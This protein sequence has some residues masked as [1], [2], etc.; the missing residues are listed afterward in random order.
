MLRLKSKITFNVASQTEPIIFDFVNDVEINISHTDLTATAKIIVPRKLTFNGKNIASGINAIFRRGDKVK[1]ELGYFPNLRT[2]FEGYISNININSPI[3]IECEDNMFLL[4]K[5]NLLYPVKYKTVTKGKKGRKL[6]HPKIIPTTIKLKDFLLQ[7]IT[8]TTNDETGVTT[9]ELELKCIIDMSINIIRFDCSAAKA[10][11]KLKSTFVGLYAYFQDG[12]LNVGLDEEAS[13]SKEVEFAFEENIIDDSN[14]FYRREEDI[15]LQ[16]R[17]TSINTVTMKRIEVTVGDED[18]AHRDIFSTKFL[19]EVDLKK[20]ATEQLNTIKYEGYV[21]SFVTFGENYV[22]PGDIASLTSKKYPEKNGKYLIRSIRRKFG[23][24][25]Y[26][27]EIELGA[28]I[29]FNKTI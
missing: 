13:D 15:K 26:R 19:N 12:V 10:L 23:M 16:V 17:A 9:K 4:K 24:N 27:Q 21:G 3:I 22:R 7:Q 18:G 14:L 8:G 28:R 5:K 29:G 25:G 2:V 11:D 1:I 6:A 20:W